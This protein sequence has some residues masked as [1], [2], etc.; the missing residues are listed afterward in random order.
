M[1]LSAGIPDGPWWN[2]LPALEPLLKAPMEPPSSAGHPPLLALKL[3]SNE[4]LEGV[5]ARVPTLLNSSYIK[6]TGNGTPCFVHQQTLGTTYLLTE[7]TWHGSPH[8]ASVP[9]RGAG[10]QQSPPQKGGI[11]FIFAR[12]FLLLQIICLNYQLTQRCE[13]G[14]PCFLRVAFACGVG[15]CG[16]QLPSFPHPSSSATPAPRVWTVTLPPRT[17]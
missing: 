8:P 5:P 1:S 11:P 3:P 7:G 13:C 14:T 10:F 4:V 17:V 2:P 16:A 15:L 6:Q 12:V 9:E